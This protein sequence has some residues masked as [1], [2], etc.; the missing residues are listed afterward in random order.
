LIVDGTATVVDDRVDV[1]PQRA[2]LHRPAPAP[3]P[4]DDSCA[5]DCSELPVERPA[6]V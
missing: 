2:V 6:Q 5:S 1:A 4:V 3:Q